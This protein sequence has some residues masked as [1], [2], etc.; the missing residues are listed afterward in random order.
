VKAERT[1]ERQEKERLREATVALRELERHQAAQQREQRRRA[2]EAQRSTAQRRAAE[3]D[4]RTLAVQTRVADLERILL[5]RHKGFAVARAR[6]EEIFRRD[7]ADAFVAVLQRGLAT[8]VYPEGLR[9][10]SAALYR[11][12]AREL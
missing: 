6:V 5:D 1:A 8:S 9:G 4:V 7:G 2:A 11:P 12:E 3:A 10:S